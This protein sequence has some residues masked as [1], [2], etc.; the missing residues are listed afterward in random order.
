MA[1]NIHKIYIISEKRYKKYM[2]SVL[3]IG[4]GRFGQ[5]LAEKFSELGDEIMA[6]DKSE[7]RV[8]FIAPIVTSARIGDCS[9][10]ETLKSLGVGNFDVCFVCIGNNFQSS[11]EVTSLLKE[12]GAKRVVS[13]AG[14]SIHAKFLLRN[15]ADEVTYPERDSAFKVASRYSV[16][17]VFD[18]I[19]LT[20]DTS[21]YEIPVIENWIGKS[22][23]QIDVRKKYKINILGIKNGDFLETLPSADYVFRGSE[24]IVVLGRNDD[25]E[26]LLKKI[27]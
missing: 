22:I 8:Q 10:P 25:A 9:I 3:I 14:T 17:N 16:T 13:K 26:K 24:H 4:L 7:E 18:V 5:H 1:G 15:G 23:M 27:K 11:L 21:I 2:K 19:E 20:K 12:M 6:V